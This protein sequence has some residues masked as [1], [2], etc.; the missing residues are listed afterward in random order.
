M[1]R[2]ERQPMEREAALRRLSDAGRS[3]SDTAVMFHA[4]A[5]ECFGLGVTD[6]KALGIIERSGPMT[7]RDLVTMIGLKPASVTNVLDRLESQQWITRTK[8]D[9]DARRISISVNKQKVSSY[10]K[11]I[12]GSL[13]DRLNGIYEQYSTEDLNLIAEALEKVA[14][15]QAAATD[16]LPRV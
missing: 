10:R 16:E 1:S 14:Q 2:L 5:A 6:W 12:F 15:A 3:V 4:R 8:A 11:Q 7:H 13:M 9:G